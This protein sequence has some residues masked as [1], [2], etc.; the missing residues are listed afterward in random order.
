MIAMYDC[1][2]Y[3]PFFFLVDIYKPFNF[4]VYFA[5]TSREIN[6]NSSKDNGNNCLEKENI[7]RIQK[8]V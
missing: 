4:D 6:E 3:I 2:F 7:F 5:L 1:L 8:V